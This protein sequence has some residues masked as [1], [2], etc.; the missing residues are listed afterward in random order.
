MND[1]ISAKLKEVVKLQDIIKKYD[2]NFVSKQKKYL[3]VSVKIH[4]LLFFGEIY[5][6]DIF[7]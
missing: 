5:M 1:F 4:Y 3:I 7:H 2:L 6:K